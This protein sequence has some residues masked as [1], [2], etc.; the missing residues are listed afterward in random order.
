[1]KRYWRNKYSGKVY[2]SYAAMMD[3]AEAL[4]NRDEYTLI[5]Q[6]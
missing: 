1:M 5:E 3:E 4:G 6:D 2:F